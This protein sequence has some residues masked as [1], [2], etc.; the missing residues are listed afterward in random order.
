MKKK[1]FLLATSAGF[2]LAPMAA[3]AA[4]LPA[5]VYKAP[6][7]PPVATWAGFYIGGHAGA[8]WQQANNTVNGGSDPFR[9]NG[10]FFPFSSSPTTTTTGFIGGGQIGYNFQ[11]GNFVYGLEAD[12]SGLTGKGKVSTG[13]TLTSI[14]V[15][16]KENCIGSGNTAFSNQIRW[17]STVRARA[18]LAVGDTMAYVT[19]G[20]A[21]GG[22]RNSAVFTSSF[23][24]SYSGSV[25]QSK[26]RVGLAVGGGVQHMWD[27]HWILGLEGMFVDLGKSTINGTIGCRTCKTSPFQAKFS[28]QAVIGRVKLDYK[29]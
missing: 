20:V 26:T 19:A 27:Q 5:P 12:G 11:H 9:T 22:V 10:Y 18:G 29:F 13:H 4:D 17:L 2:A 8:A 1:G 7:P 16:G 25:S 14:S 3:D 21:I 28:N 6:P 15:C 23:G 24:S